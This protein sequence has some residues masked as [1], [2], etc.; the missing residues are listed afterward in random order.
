MS[1]TDAERSIP[2]GKK[3]C[4]VPG[5]GDC[6]VQFATSGYPRKLRREMDGTDA[7]GVWAII[8]RYVTSAHI[9][10]LSGAEVTITPDLTCV[11][12]VEDAVVTWINR[13]FYSFW[14]TELTAPRPNS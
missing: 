3:F 8:A 1:E 12:D 7:A 2:F 14:L 4:E 9:H 11:D 6:W 10:N 5:Y 13:A